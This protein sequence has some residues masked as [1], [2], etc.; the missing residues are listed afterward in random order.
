MSDEK[1]DAERHDTAARGAAEPPKAEPGS[2]AP[3]KPRRDTRFRPGESGNYKGR[4]PKPQRA[5]IPTQLGEDIRAVGRRIT[6]INT[7]D[8]PLRVTL[9]EAL[10]YKLWM[11]A[12]GGKISQQR[13]LINA[14]KSALAENV[15]LD[16]IL[17]LMNPKVAASLSS[18]LDGKEQV[19]FRGQLARRSRMSPAERIRSVPDSAWPKSSKRGPKADPESD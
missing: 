14:L 13:M 5:E 9:Y 7:P 17:S 3:R 4:P 15:A 6:T 2:A 19:A 16:P 10:A 12:L 1:H 18:G 11:D 8:G